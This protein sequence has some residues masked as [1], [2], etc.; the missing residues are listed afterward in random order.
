MT[1]VVGVVVFVG[2][3]TLGLILVGVVVLDVGVVGVVGFLCLPFG[4]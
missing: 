4:E 1:L 2:E 3:V